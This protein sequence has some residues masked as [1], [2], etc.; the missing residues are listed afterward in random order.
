M[1]ASAFKPV[2]KRLPTYQ[3]MLKFVNR[4]I[5]GHCTQIIKNYLKKLSEKFIITAFTDSHNHW[6]VKKS[7]KII[8]TERCVDEKCLKLN[9]LSNEVIG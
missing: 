5:G 1:G 6:I 9:Y 4:Q 8:F 7:E 3:R 2:H